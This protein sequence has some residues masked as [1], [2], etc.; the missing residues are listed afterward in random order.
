MSLCIS[1]AMDQGTPQARPFGFDRSF[2]VNDTGARPMAE[3]KVE[4]A[5]KKAPPPPPPPTFSAEDVE[6]ARRDGYNKGRT[7][8]TAEAEASLDSKLVQMLEKI[9]GETK[10]LLDEQA[11]MDAALTDE[12]IRIA[13]AL[14]GKLLP[15][16][17]E[18][19]GLDE[20]E[21]LVRACLADMIEE[22]RIVVRVAD[23]MLDPMRDRLAAIPGE[24]GFTGKVILLSDDALTVGDCRVEWADGGAERI[25]AT[26]W[27][28]IEEIAGRV[29]RAKPAET[30][31]SEPEP[32]GSQTPGAP[33]PSSPAVDSGEDTP[34]IATRRAG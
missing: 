31:P 3:A 32:D 18:R 25:S 13:V 19:H 2:D 23:T 8:A 5:A 7:T 30:T 29:L 12:A 9:D 1:T 33:P 15:G 27:Q 4:T 21:H 28:D 16:L 11:A 22:P 14:I 6:A 34:D 20:A 24:A 26:L 10:R 17:A